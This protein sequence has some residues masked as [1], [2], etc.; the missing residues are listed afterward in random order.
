MIYYHMIGLSKLWPVGP[1]LI[2]SLFFYSAQDN[3]YITK[4]LP[5]KQKKIENENNFS[6][7][8]KNP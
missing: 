2:H 8:T 1:N 3:F 6:W 4:C 7:H 5:K